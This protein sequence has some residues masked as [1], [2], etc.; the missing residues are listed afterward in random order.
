MSFLKNIRKSSA[1]SRH[2]EEKLYEDVAKELSAN[3]RREGLWVKAIG[4]SLGDE[5]KTEALYIQLRVQSLKD[6]ALLQVQSLKGEVQSLKDEM[7]LPLANTP[8]SIDAYDS[9]GYT[10]LMQ[11]VLSVDHAAVKAL[12]KQGADPSIMDNNFGTATALTLARRTLHK[13]PD[14]PQLIEIISTLESLEGS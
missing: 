9:D 1:S 4:Q 7:T 5:K 12:L 6:E 2:V 10:A 3:I 11:A 14:Y 8:K 13:V